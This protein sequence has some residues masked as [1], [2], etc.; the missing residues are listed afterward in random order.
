MSKWREVRLGEV[1]PFKYGKSKKADERQSG[2]YGVYSSAGHCGFSNDFLAEKGIIVGRKGTIG[3]VYFSKSPFYCIDTAFYIDEVNE[4]VSISFMYYYMQIL[5]LEQYNTDAAVPGLNRNL[6]HNIKIQIPDLKTQE[7][8]ANIL[9]TYDKL[10][11]NNNRRIEILE[12]TAEEI[13]KEWF[14]RMRFPGY[15]EAKFEKGIPAGWEVRKVGE[16]VNRLQTGHFYKEEELLEEGEVIVIDQSTKEYM[17]FH[18]E[19]ATHEADIDKPIILFGDHSC[20]MIVMIRKFSLG[21]NIVPFISRF[22]HSVLFLYYS[23]KGLI[24]TEEYKR[25]WKELINKKICYPGI[26]LQE[27]F[28]SAIKDK[29]AIIEKYKVQNQNLI[30]QRDLL[31][32]RLMNGTIEVK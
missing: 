20:K 2:K 24:K 16:V 14:V 23:I 32:P 28:E 17:G 25:H 29:I 7:K 3:S 13:Y 11:E 4:S 31:L 12:K 1:V 21:E 30:K 18:N 26:R 27:M 5:K 8:T 6:A 19:E 9:S 15:K 10:I 22:N